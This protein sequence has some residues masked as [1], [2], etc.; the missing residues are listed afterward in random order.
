VAS[1][2]SAPNSCCGE[3][4]PH[5]NTTKTVAVFSNLNTLPSKEPR[6]N[7]LKHAEQSALVT[8]NETSIALRPPVLS[9][10]HKP[11]YLLIYFNLLEFFLPHLLPPALPSLFP[12]SSTTSCFLL[13]FRHPFVLFILSFILGSSLLPVSTLF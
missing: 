9:F 8:Q 11:F 1:P 6:F 12:A 4:L 3:C 2:A 7:A 13:S 5:I 10:R